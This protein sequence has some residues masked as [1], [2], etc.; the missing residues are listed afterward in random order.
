MLQS[1]RAPS[2]LIQS[3]E[4]PRRTCPGAPAPGPAAARPAQALL[5]AESRRQLPPLPRP[6]SRWRVRRHSEAEDGGLDCFALGPTPLGHVGISLP[7]N[8][9]F[10][11]RHGAGGY[12]LLR[13]QAAAGARRVCRRDARG[14][15]RRGGGDD[16]TRPLCRSL[17]RRDLPLPLLGDVVCRALPRRAMAA[18]WGRRRVS[19]AFPHTP[20]RR[21]RPRRRAGGRRG[22]RGE[23]GQSG[24][25]PVPDPACSACVAA[26]PPVR[27]APP[28]ASPRDPPLPSAFCLPTRPSSCL[29]APDRRTFPFARS[30]APLPCSPACLP[31]LLACCAVLPSPGCPPACPPAHRPACLSV[32]LSEPRTG[33]VPALAPAGVRGGTR[34]SLATT[35]GRGSLRVKSCWRHARW[36]DSRLYGRAGPLRASPGVLLQGTMHSRALLRVNLP[37]LAVCLT[38]SK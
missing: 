25:A 15:A 13:P 34:R 8:Y 10:L 19:W 35:S 2:G 24:A 27:P 38:V 18:P 26:C 36:L 7:Q 6:C 22:R 4:H 1:G 37:S 31:A 11:G 5:P 21:G 29:P 16:D 20:P 30:P 14:E 12:F 9:Y 28:P 33:P 3:E 32:C 23:I 17:P